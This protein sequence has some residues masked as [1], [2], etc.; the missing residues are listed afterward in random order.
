MNHFFRAALLLAVFSTAYQYKNST[1]KSKSDSATKMSR[2]HDGG[3]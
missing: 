2:D 1:P 3:P